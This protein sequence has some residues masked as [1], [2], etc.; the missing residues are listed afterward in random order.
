LGTL[1]VVT[2]VAL[3]LG[4]GWHFFQEGAT[5]LPDPSWTAA[6]FFTGSKGP[7]HPLYEML[8]WDVDGKIRLNYAQTE[9]GW[10]RID[11]DQTR[12][13]WDAYRAQVEEYYGFDDKQKE[14]AAACQEHWEDQLR[15]YFA[16]NEAKI[17]EYFH[18]LDRAQ[19]NARDV[20]KRQVASLRG[21][22]EKIDAELTGAAAPWLAQVTKL[23]AGYDDAI[24][25]VATP[26]QRARG[27]LTMGNLQPGFFNT[28]LAH[29]IDR[30]VPYF[31][32]AV[33]ALLIVGLFTRLAA[34][35][36]AGFLFSIILTQWPGA[37]GA[38]PVYYQTIEMLGM[39][40]LAAVAAGQFAGLD[41]V[42]YSYWSR[43]TQSK[44]E[45]NP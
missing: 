1:A 30:F 7:L 35:A 23:W 25:A 21:Q 2:L 33:G 36:G 44:Q 31:D 41:Y 28:T 45:K 18:G 43:F 20:A 6:H 38:Q 4:I 22:A 29:F 16:E 37:P 9:H 19:A 32:A 5:K 8:V 42:L 13:F 27:R 11:L 10:P 12:S 15:A 3:R 24:N 14:Q 17:L 34:L 40:V 26:E 39:L